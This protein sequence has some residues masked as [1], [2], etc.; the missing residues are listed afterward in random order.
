MATEK[1]QLAKV[2]RTAEAA[3]NWAERRDAAIVEASAA[4]ASR[5]AVAEAAGL[6][7]ARVQQLVAAARERG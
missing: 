5:R 1:Q 2:Q 7:F 4:G 3:R 6:S